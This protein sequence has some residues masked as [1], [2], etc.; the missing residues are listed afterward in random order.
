MTKDNADI[1]F[2]GLVRIEDD[3]KTRI[4]DDSMQHLACYAG[5]MMAIGGKIFRRGGDLEKARKLVD[6]CIWAYDSL[7]NGLMAEVSHHIPCPS[8]GPENCTR[9]EERWHSAI[10]RDEPDEE[11]TSGMSYDDRV[12]RRIEEQRLRPGYVSIDDRRYIP[13]A[14]AIESIFVWYRISGD[15][16]YQDKAWTMFEAIE[17]HT[18]TDIAH[19]ALDDVTGSPPTKVDRTESF[20]MAESLKYFYLTF[21]EPGVVSLDEYVFNTRAHPFRRPKR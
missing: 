20:W 14:E 6:G 5:G 16:T 12:A 19:A 2:S 7:Q 1:L 18:R 10:M 15:K 9:N 4:L 21:S 8:H 17:N 13:R 3:R 11:R